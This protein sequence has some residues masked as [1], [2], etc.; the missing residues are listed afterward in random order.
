MHARTIKRRAH[1]HTLTFILY[2]RTRAH[3]VHTTNTFSHTHAHTITPTH[4]HTPLF[5]INTHRAYN[6]DH[7]ARHATSRPKH[8]QAHTL[9]AVWRAPHTQRGR[10]WLTAWQR[11]AV[12]PSSVYGPA[13]PVHSNHLPRPHR[14][15]LRV[16]ETHQ[17][18]TE[19]AVLRARVPCRYSVV[20]LLFY[21]RVVCRCVFYSHCASS[22]SVHFRF[23]ILLAVSMCE[24]ACSNAPMNTY[25]VRP[26]QCKFALASLSAHARTSDVLGAVQAYKR[27][28]S[29]WCVDVCA[30]NTIVR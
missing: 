17:N 28:F 1:T 24:A 16:V 25:E 29:T 5:A 21:D 8:T 18:G 6:G 19:T 12:P 3:H 7:K 9:K 23:S 27:A 26:M 4:T 14:G 10:G 2:M 11:S 22:A 15:C 30:I 13:P 20:L